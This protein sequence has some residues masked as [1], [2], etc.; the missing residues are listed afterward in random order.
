MEVLV[1]PTEGSWVTILLVITF[2]VVI[3]SGVAVT[4]AGGAVEMVVNGVAV[5]GLTGQ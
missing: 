1:L 5:V 2:T 4:G 3:S